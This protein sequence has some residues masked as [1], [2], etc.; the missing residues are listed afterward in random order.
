ME[1]SFLKSALIVEPREHPASLT[2]LKNIRANIPPEAPIVWF[3]GTQNREFAQ[4]VSKQIENVMLREIPVSN[5]DNAQEYSG[6]MLNPNLYKELRHYAKR[7]PNSKVLVFQTDSG[8]CHV[9]NDNFAEYM[10]S[11]EHIDYA[12]APGRNHF[13]GGFS[14]RDIDSMIKLTTNVDDLPNDSGLWDSGF[15]VD[16]VQK[17]RKPAEDRVLSSGCQ[18]KEWCKLATKEE[19]EQLSCCAVNRKHSAS[20]N[21]MAFHGHPHHFAGGP[22]APFKSIDELYKAC[23]ESKT[24]LNLN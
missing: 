7:E 21:S 5:F 18:N 6:F 23:P 4:H 3:H 19:A 20:W 15:W 17:T 1:T 12:G 11:A 16:D 8:F 2:V 9:D 13:N 22:A 24:I 14:L 10:R